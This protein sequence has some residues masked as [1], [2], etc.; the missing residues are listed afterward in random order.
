[1][2]IRAELKAQL[3]AQIATGDLHIGPHRTG[4][5]KLEGKIP[6]ERENVR[7]EISFARGGR[8][9]EQ[10]CAGKRQHAEEWMR[11]HGDPL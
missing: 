11:F 2:L 3:L 9:G 10:G 4:C 7:L 8:N 6:F 5:I 1:M